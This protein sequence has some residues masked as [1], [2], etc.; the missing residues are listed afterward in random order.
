[1][2]GAPHLHTPTAS[3]NGH[4]NRT[5]YVNRYKDNGMVPPEQ[6]Y[7]GKSRKIRI[8]GIIRY[9]AGIHPICFGKCDTPD[10]E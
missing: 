6:L 7:G 10:P 1:M 5:K 4:T 9:D 8:G 2:Y 3:S